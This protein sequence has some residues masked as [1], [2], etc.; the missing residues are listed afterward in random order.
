V[1][2]RVFYEANTTFL[3]S[4]GNDI[5]INDNGST[6]AGQNGSF[7]NCVSAVYFCN[8]KTGVTEVGSGINANEDNT[9]CD[10]NGLEDPN[11]GTCVA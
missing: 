10:T 8:G 6:A 7:V 11:N 2:I 5:Y 4:Q 9:N 3:H 1:I